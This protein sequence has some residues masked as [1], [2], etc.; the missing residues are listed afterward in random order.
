MTFY[1]CILGLH[2]MGIYETK[3]GV[4][5]KINNGQRVLELVTSGERVLISKLSSISFI[6][7]SSKMSQSRMKSQISTTIVCMSMYCDRHA[8]QA[9]F[10]WIDCCKC[11][12]SPS[13]HW[14]LVGVSI[15]HTLMA[16]R[17]LNVHGKCSHLSF[18]GWKKK[19][20]SMYLVR[21]KTFEVISIT[22]KC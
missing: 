5:D 12:T 21:T 19:Q 1:R 3:N 13:L 9:W 22:L 4:S 18:S 10:V 7:S 16:P 8:A 14:T 2:V 20:K 17:N 6:V 11:S 15:I